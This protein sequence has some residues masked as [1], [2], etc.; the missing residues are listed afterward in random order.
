M[1]PMTGVFTAAV[2]LCVT[3]PA[4]VSAQLGAI[5][6][7]IQK[8][9]GPAMLYIGGSYRGGYQPGQSPDTTRTSGDRTAELLPRLHQD[10]RA[11]ASRCAETI[12]A[13]LRLMADNF[14]D[15]RSIDRF[16][17]QRARL[18]SLTK[19][20]GREGQLDSGLSRDIGNILC[21]QMNN[22]TDATI[23]P[24]YGVVWRIGLFYGWDTREDRPDDVDIRSWMAQGTLELQFPFRRLDSFDVGLEAGLAV[25][26]FF[27]DFDNFRHLTI[28]VKF[29]VHP[30]ARCEG[31]IPRNLRVGTGFHIVPDF[32]AGAFGGVYELG[33]DWEITRIK[34]FINLDVSKD[35]WKGSDPFLC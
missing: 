26:S 19:Q 11:S 24:K 35:S 28:P 34:L 10:Y 25:H 21:L 20:V 12:Q 30:F 18:A 17:A 9:S 14:Y 1:K 8:M 31:W 23:S 32:D 13:R 27:G 22:L 16:R 29:N 2:L 5:I 4:P 6:D 33:D 7:Q 3:S 15:E